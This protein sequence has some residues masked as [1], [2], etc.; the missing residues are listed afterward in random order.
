MLGLIEVSKWM[1]KTPI[2]C[3][4]CKV[5]L[6]FELIPERVEPTLIYSVF[7]VR[8]SS[9]VGLSLS[10]AIT[11][12]MSILSHRKTVFRMAENLST[13]RIKITKMSSIT[14]LG[15]EVWVSPQSEKLW[16][17]VFCDCEGCELRWGWMT[18]DLHK[19]S[20]L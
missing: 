18:N 16:F 8:S 9:M 12:Y 19:I 11:L 17:I 13:W 20:H 2:E 10:F 15:L 6:K 14:K 5:C 3:P 1:A 7:N 4:W